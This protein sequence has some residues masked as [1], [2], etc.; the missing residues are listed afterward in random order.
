[1]IFD[2]IDLGERG[3]AAVAEERRAAIVLSPE[4]ASLSTARVF[5]SSMLELWECEDPDQVARLLTSE[6]VSNAVRHAASTIELE[7]AMFNEQQLRVR[8][9]DEAP[10]AR[11]EPDP[12]R[13]EGEGGHGLQIIESLAERWG[14]ERYEDHKVVWFETFALPRSTRLR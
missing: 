9:R 13:P 14:V 7:V 1:V 12:H 2:G 3:V 4:V 10:Q 5:V 11:V 6:V 8:A